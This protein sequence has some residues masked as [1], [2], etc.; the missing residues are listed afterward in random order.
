[1]DL[2]FRGLEERGGRARP[3]CRLAR[4]QHP[5]KPN[6][7]TQNQ[8]S[9]SEYTLEQFQA[10]AAAKAR[11][12]LTDPGAAAA[13]PLFAAADYFRLLGGTAPAEV[14]YGDNVDPP[15]PVEE[16]DDHDGRGH[17]NL[18]NN[19]DD[20][21]NSNTSF[22]AGHPSLPRLVRASAI[23]PL[24]ERAG[25][26]LPGINTPLLYVGMALASFG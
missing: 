2:F 10:T 3:L 13:A 11:D 18:N 9:S 21:N 25:V 15:A 16:D 5:A 23:G 20:S 7:K 6:P 4:P 26:V 12:L 19:N 8:K 17:P 24:L 14:M 1:M 22:T